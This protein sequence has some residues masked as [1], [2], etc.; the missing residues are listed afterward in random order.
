MLN[1]I[2]YKVEFLDGEIKK[3]A[4]NVIAKSMLTQLDFEGF[5]TTMM[6]GIIDYDMDDNNAVHIRD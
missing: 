1:S 2:V 3:Y 6:E 4:A 5:T